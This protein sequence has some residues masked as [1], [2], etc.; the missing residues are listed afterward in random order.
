MKWLKKGLVYVPDGK[1]AWA[2]HSALQPT[3]ILISDNVIR[4]YVGFRDEN[5][6]S[7]VGFVDVNANNPSV[8]LKVS[9]KPVLDIGNPGTFDE[10][11]VVPCAIV[12]RRGKLY[13]YYAG[14][15]LGQKVRF[16]VFGGLAISEDGGDFFSRYSNVPII[17]R[18]DEALLFRVIHS[19]IFENGVWRIWY[20]A[21]SE[22]IQGTTKTLPVYDVRY[23]E[24][25]DGINISK[26]GRSC[27][28]VKGGDEHR[29]GRPYVIKDGQTH[30]MFYGVGTQ[31]KGY[32]LGYAES[33]DGLSW[34][35]K[36]E[37]VGIDISK[38]GWDSEMI[39]YPSVVKHAE[40]TYMFYNGNDYGK[41]G[42]GYAVLEKW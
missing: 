35:R 11:G 37:D 29:V 21:G 36:D 22:F 18:S 13:L 26:K 30:R 3:P 8:V 38:S 27:I 41:T 7:R 42:F 32:R 39:A 16:Y 33:K 24:S 9:E 25:E 12:K 10:N 31:S 5:G 14:Y 28:N 1:M 17:D 40:K 4:V 19:I 2:K 34:M 15:Q 6:V 23:L 20:G